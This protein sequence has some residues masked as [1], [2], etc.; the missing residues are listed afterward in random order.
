MTSF[1]C[2]SS[3]LNKVFEAVEIHDSTVIGSAKKEDAISSSCRKESAVGSKE[4]KFLLEGKKDV[5]SRDHNG[6]EAKS[7]GLASS[8][9]SPPIPITGKNKREEEEAPYEEDFEFGDDSDQVW[10]MDQK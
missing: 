10:Y 9:K 1:R 4:L 3:D 8:C 2:S 7:A 5:D 6:L